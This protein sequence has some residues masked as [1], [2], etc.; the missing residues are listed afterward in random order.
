MEAHHLTALIV[1]DDKVIRTVHGRML[2]NIA[3]KNQAVENGQEAV[4]IHCSGQSFDLILMDRDMPIMN[5]IE[6]TK[7][8]R[9]MGIRSTI[10]GVSTRSEEIHI[11]E[12]MEAGLDGYLE[13]PLNIEKLNSIVQK[14]NQHSE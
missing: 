6:A 7:K 12:Y 2:N 3:I 1:E 9:S 14:I 5:G 13:K 8:L 10:I 4:D 11:N